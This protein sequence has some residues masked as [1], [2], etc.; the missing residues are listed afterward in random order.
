MISIYLRIVRIAVSMHCRVLVNGRNVDPLVG[1]G[2]ADVNKAVS[3]VHLQYVQ[4]TR[5]GHGVGTPLLAIDQ[6]CHHGLECGPRMVCIQARGRV[7]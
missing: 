5:E 3:S 7:E 1:V 6:F 4:Q 2:G